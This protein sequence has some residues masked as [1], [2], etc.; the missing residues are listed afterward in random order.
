MSYTLAFALQLRK[1]QGKTSGRV[2]EECQSARSIKAEWHKTRASCICLICCCL[3][4]KVHSFT[5]KTFG[6]ELLVQCSCV[7]LA[8]TSS[9][10]TSAMAWQKKLDLM[11]KLDSGSNPV[12]EGASGSSGSATELS[13]LLPPPAMPLLATFLATRR[14]VPS[15]SFCGPPAIATD[16]TDSVD[17][18]ANV[19]TRQRRLKRTRRA[20]R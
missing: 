10:Q 17:I 7:L 2:A 13:S 4:T 15:G 14:E 19:R 6:Y 3:L 18:W 12:G 5:S 16:P 8:G 11:G 20:H 1:K 9:P